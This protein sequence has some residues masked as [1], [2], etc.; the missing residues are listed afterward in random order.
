M[1]RSAAST[2]VWR[3]AGRTVLVAALVAVS[4]SSRLAASGE[5]FPLL[6]QTRGSLAQVQALWIDWLAK[7][8]SGDVEGADDEVG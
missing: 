4:L 3:W 1:C 8:G 6:P 7:I 2:Q 5:P